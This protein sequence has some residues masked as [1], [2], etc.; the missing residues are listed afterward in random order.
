MGWLKKLAGF[1][2]SFSKDFIKDIGNDPTRLFTGIDPASTK[3][4]N[5]V[6]GSD[7]QALVNQLGSPGQQYYDQA[8]ARGIDTGPARGFHQVADVVAGLFGANGLAGIGGGAAG[9]AGAG[10]GAA[11]AGAAGAGAAGAGSAAAGIG[12]AAGA[13]GAGGA[14][15]AGTGMWGSLIGTGA[16]LVGNYFSSK[17]AKDAA[18]AASSSQQQAA[19]LGIDEQRRQFDA[20]QRLLAPYVGAGVSGI[21]GQQALLG[22]S[23]QP[24][25]QAAISG[26][27]SSPMFSSMA[28]QGENAILQNASATGGL[29]GGNTQGALAQFRPGL[30]NSLIDQQYSRLGG[31]TQIGQ[32][33]AAGVGAAG[34]QTGNNVA[35]LM[36]QQ[37]A[38]QAGAQLAGGRADAGMISGITGAIGQFIGNKF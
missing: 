35:N 19:Q 16:S 2:N 6:T 7:N 28:Q 12:G 23:G 36:Q 5:S 15:A 17:S 25:Q 37:G 29:R 32:A 18:N 11:G 13:A 22:L 34:M 9:A 33:S 38:A 31:L 3:L 4:W 14:A 26:I 21:Q 24:A 20:V 1:E 27:E 8:E 10:A 30:L